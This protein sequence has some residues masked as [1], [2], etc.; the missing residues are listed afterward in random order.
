MPGAGDAVLLPGQ[1][2]AEY[3]NTKLVYLSPQIA[4]FDFGLQ[5]APNTSNG[6]GIGTGNNAL[7][8]VDHRRRHRHRPWLRDGG[9]SGCPNLSSGPGIQDGSRVTNQ[10]VVGVRYQGTFGGLG[11]LAYAAYEHSGHANYTGLTTPADPRHHR[12]CR[13]ARS[14]AATTA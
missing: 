14:T 8:G 3:D 1:A 9:N 7:N 13:A 12:R 5:W 6:Y 4:G 10:T 2:G 11:V